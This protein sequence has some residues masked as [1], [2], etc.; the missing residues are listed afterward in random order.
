MSLKAKW[1][2][3]GRVA[4]SFAEGKPPSRANGAGRVLGSSEWCSLLDPGGG[5]SAQESGHASFPEG[6]VPPGFQREEPPFGT[7]RAG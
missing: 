7:R 5:A 6:R 2:P 1:F 4:F 3:E